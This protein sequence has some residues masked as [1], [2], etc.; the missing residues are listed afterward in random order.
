MWKTYSNPDPHGLSVTES[1]NKT[2]KQN[3]Q[4]SSN[5]D[6]TEHVNIEMTT[7]NNFKAEHSADIVK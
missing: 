3:V 2:F 6:V 7:P 5:R 4:A 1:S